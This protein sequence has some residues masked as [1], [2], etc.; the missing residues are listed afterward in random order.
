MMVPPIFGKASFLYSL[1]TKFYA[2]SIHFNTEWKIKL[3]KIEFVKIILIPL[4]HRKILL[5]Y[6]CHPSYLIGMA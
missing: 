3:I 1:Q 4:L 2:A 5:N 6:I